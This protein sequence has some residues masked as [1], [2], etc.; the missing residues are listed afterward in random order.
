MKNL[1]LKEALGIKHGDSVVFD[2]DLNQPGIRG[3]VYGIPGLTKGMGLE[4]RQ[5][6]A[7]NEIDIQFGTEIRSY[8]SEGDH[9]SASI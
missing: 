1:T 6:Y 9:I 4:P 3:Q 7:V 2:P 5:K 8:H